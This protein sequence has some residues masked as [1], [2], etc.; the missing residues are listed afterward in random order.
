MGRGLAGTVP[1]GHLHE[2]SLERL[3]VEQ[4][5]AASS[6]KPR[7]LFASVL[8]TSGR[9]STRDARLLLAPS[10]LTDRLA[11]PPR[12]W[13][14]I[15]PQRIGGGEARRTAPAVREDVDETGAPHRGA[16]ECW[17]GCGQEVGHGVRQPI[18]LREDERPSHINLRE[19]VDDGEGT[20]C[21]PAAPACCG[22]GAVKW[23]WPP[24]VDN[25][26]IGACSLEV[27]K[28]QAVTPQ[29]NDART[30]SRSST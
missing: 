15:A 29:S 6:L 19:E 26:E 30:R 20:R 7:Q 17:P 8:R 24:G 18:V 5:E 13:L 9:T 2:P 3:D 16:H 21:I 10:V 11:D 23:V 28:P 25:A 14:P 12:D 1:R 22:P 27:T 4:S